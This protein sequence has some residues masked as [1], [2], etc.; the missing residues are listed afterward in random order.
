MSVELANK[1][2]EA[3]KKFFGRPMGETTE[4]IFKDR[5]SWEVMEEV[6]NSEFGTAHKL[7]SD[8][9]NILDARFED[10]S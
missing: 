6:I 7:V 9:G 4:A 10:R 5:H 2:L 1:R 3:W 8:T